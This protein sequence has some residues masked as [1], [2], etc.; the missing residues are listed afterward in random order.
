MFLFTVKYTLLLVDSIFYTQVNVTLSIK[1][2][3]NIILIYYQK[4]IEF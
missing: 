3:F 4:F 2:F 1:I